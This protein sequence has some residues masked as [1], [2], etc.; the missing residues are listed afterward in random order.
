M[1]MV[2]YPIDLLMTTWWVGNKKHTWTNEFGFAIIVFEHWDPGM[3]WNN[4][5]E[6]HEHES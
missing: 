5:S 2:D 6:Q 4:H 1:A 3:D